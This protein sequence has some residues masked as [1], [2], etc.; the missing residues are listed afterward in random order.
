MSRRQTLSTK[1]NPIDKSFHETASELCERFDW[2][3]RWNGRVAHVLGRIARAFV[4]CDGA[5]KVRRSVQSY[6]Y[7]LVGACVGALARRRA[8]PSLG[9]QKLRVLFSR[10]ATVNCLLDEFPPFYP[11]AELANHLD[12]FLEFLGGHQAFL[13]RPGLPPEP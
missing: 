5:S 13:I 4:A 7:W 1:T 10:I 12:S 3:K 2:P 9:R 6:A 11:H 8:L